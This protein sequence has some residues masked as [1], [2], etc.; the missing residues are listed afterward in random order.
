MAWHATG[1]VEQQEETRNL[2]ENIFIRIK[3]R[4]LQISNFKRYCQC[5]DILKIFSH[6]QYRFELEIWSGL[7]V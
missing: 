7:E 6:R 4:Q 1:N 2:E 3:S 5:L